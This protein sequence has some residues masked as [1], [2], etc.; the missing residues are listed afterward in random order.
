MVEARPPVN[1]CSFLLPYAARIYHIIA[2]I[3]SL[4]LIKMLSVGDKHG[5][6]KGTKGT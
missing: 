2:Y 6:M 1:T 3:L 5:S 4:A